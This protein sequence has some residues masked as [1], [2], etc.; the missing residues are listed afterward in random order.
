MNAEEYKDIIQKLDNI[1]KW[2]DYHVKE[3]L[4]KTK[5]HDRCRAMLVEIYTHVKNTLLP[6]RP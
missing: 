6:T 5:E 1:Q 2:I 4:I 3:D